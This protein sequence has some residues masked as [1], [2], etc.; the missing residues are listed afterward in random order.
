LIYKLDEK[1]FIVLMLA[2]TTH[3]YRR[4]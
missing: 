4:Q 3:D 2:V 1:H